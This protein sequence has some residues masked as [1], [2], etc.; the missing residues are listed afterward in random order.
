[1]TFTYTAS[2]D[3]EDIDAVRLLVGDVDPTEPQLQD[4]EIQFLIDTWSYKGS[5]YYVASMA[6]ETIA[7]R[8][9]REINLSADSQSL[10]TGELQQKYL[11]LAERLRML[12]DQLF[13]GGIVDAG[14]ITAGEQPDP[15][16][17]PLSFGLGM[18]DDPEA[19]QQNFGG[20]TVPVWLPEIYGGS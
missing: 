11:T 14:G 1:M 4:E 13:A 17:K 18:H 7:S 19:G 3:D 15:T 2:P 16:V 10:Q 8:Y 5:N 6:A 12:H 9:T 20:L